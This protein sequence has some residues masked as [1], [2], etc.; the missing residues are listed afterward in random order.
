MYSLQEILPQG[1]LPPNFD[2]PEQKALHNPKLLRCELLQG[3][4]KLGV[5]LQDF[6]NNIEEHVD[7]SRQ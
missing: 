2:F 5:P 7:N 1:R 4:R 6:L 3:N